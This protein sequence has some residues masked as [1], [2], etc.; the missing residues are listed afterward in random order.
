MKRLRFIIPILVL[1]LI[2]GF[3]FATACNGT[4]SEVVEPEG[5]SVS[6]KVAVHNDTE[7]NEPDLEIWI[8][9]TG[10]W[11]PDEEAMGFGGDFFI[12]TEPF[13]TKEE[14][15]IYIYP[16]GRAGKEIMVEIIATDEMTA[17]SDRDTIHIEIHDKIVKVWGTGL[18]EFEK[19]F[20]R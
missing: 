6:L 7:I 20:K 11:Y 17:E 13:S 4:E 14:N 16:D 12:P 3:G 5:E 2:F 8:K 10:S 19:E 18:E 1:A 9:G 15:E